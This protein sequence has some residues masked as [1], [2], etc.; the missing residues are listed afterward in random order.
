MTIRKVEYISEEKEVESRVTDP[1][2]V[3]LD[4]DPDPDPAMKKKPDLDPTVENQPGS[5]SGSDLIST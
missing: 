1:G 2:G 4:P 5:I 3:D